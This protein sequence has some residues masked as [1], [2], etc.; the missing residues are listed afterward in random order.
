VQRNLSKNLNGSQIKSGKPDMA[1]AFP[2]W[3]TEGTA[4][5]VGKSVGALSQNATYW[6]GR[7]R[8]FSYAPRE[9]SIDKNA[10]AE[11]TIYLS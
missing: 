8:M 11:T 7:E 9:E 10:I 3:F 2:A 4:D 1:N 5:F 6:E